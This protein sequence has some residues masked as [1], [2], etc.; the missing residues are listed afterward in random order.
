MNLLVQS[1]RSCSLWTTLF[2]LENYI[3]SGQVRLLW[4]SMFSLDKYVYFGQLRLLWTTTF[5]FDK[6]VYFGQIRSLWTCTFTLDNY[7][8]FR[9]LH[10]LWTSTITLD[11]YV[12]FG[13]LRSLWTTVLTFDNYLKGINFRGKKIS[14]ISQILAK[15]AKLNSFF[16]PQKRPFAKINSSKFFMNWWT[17]NIRVSFELGLLKIISYSVILLSKKSINFYWDHSQN[18]KLR[19]KLMSHSRKLILAKSLVKPIREN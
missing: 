9:Q 8:H 15:Y 12:Y 1:K 4:T 10:L 3:Y 11:S 19:S 17:A 16:D 14:R 6:Y 2:T 5:T 13:Q 7:V 18:H